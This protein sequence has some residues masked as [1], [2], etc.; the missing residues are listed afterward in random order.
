[1][2]VGLGCGVEV[3]AENWVGVELASKVAVRVGKGVSVDAAG[4]FLL[5]GSEG[6]KLFLVV[7]IEHPAANRVNR[8]ATPVST[9]GRRCWLNIRLSSFRHPVPIRDS[10]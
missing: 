2:E 9:F 6:V 7:K 3:G 4:K 5:L 10:R 1:M 8:I